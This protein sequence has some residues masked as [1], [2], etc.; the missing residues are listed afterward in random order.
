MTAAFDLK[1]F[2]YE[3]VLN[4][5]PVAH[6]VVILGT[7]KPEASEDEA[8]PAI[9]RIE[10]TALP[11]F[12]ED[13]ISHASLI[14]DTDIYKW[15]FGWL[16]TSED[17]PDVKINVVYPATEVHVRK[18]SKQNICIVHE[19]PAMYEKVVKPYID[20]FPASR[21]QWVD[22]ILSGRAEA[23]K[24]LFRSPSDVDGFLILPDMKWDLT[25]IPSLYL[26]ALTLFKDIRS[27]RDLNRGHVPLLQTIRREARRV[28]GERWGLH[29]NQLRLFVHYH[30]SYYHFHVHIVNANHTGLAGMT[31]GQSHLLDDIISMLELDPETG[32][33]IFQRLT[34][35]YGLGEQHGLFELMN[36][37]ESG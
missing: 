18:Y 1:G 32:P 10:K 28:V 9:V 13:L 16:K 14:G 5:D 34:L 3:R 8:R 25:T 33:S 12:S 37:A 6:S 4:E 31:V 19:T 22:E 15:M 29:P 27:L 20:A 17:R 21:T 35:T 23:E 26:V 2:K 30:P 7:Y 36:A 24:I 11:S